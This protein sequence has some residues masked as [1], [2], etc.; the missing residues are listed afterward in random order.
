MIPLIVESL[1]LSVKSVSKSLK[2]E[3]PTQIDDNI[4]Q[5]NVENSHPILKELRK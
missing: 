1:L 5:W 2:R 3:L 4:A